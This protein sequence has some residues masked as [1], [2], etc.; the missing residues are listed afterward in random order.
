MGTRNQVGIGLSYR[1]VSLC[2]LAPQFQT[3]F[4]ESIPR[5]IAELKFPTLAGGP[6]RQPYLSY[7][8]ARL[9]RLPESI[10]WN[11]FL[12]SL[13]VYIFGLCTYSCRPGYFVKTSIVYHAA[14]NTPHYPVKTGLDS[15]VSGSGIGR[16]TML[17][18]TENHSCLLSL[19]LELAPTPSPC[20][21]CSDDSNLPSLSL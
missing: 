16:L 19:Q 12:S 18:C 15:C 2:S 21:Q 14:H 5:P 17:V 10:P 13:K 20:Q 4:L 1:P 8:S 9:H 7:R 3:R 6:V 11:Q